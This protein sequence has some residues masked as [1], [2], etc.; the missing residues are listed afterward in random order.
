MSIGVSYG[1]QNPLC[2]N[3][4]EKQRKGKATTKKEKI[5]N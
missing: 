2:S 3:T 4:E 1:D 5:L